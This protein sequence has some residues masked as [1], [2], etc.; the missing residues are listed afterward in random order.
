[1][2]AADYHHANNARRE[3][4]PVDRIDPH[5]PAHDVAPGTNRLPDVGIVCLKNDEPAEY[6]EKIHPEVTAVDDVGERSDAVASKGQ[7][8]YGQRQVEGSDCHCS[9]S[10]TRLERDKHSDLKKS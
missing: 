9:Q 8:P 5:E 7:I 4:D 6:E 1:M 3:V 2:R 10:A